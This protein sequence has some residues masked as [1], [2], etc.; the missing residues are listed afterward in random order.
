M[1]YTKELT[2]IINHY[3]HLNQ[4]IVAMEEFDELGQAVAKDLRGDG[5]RDNLVE[6]IADCEIMLTQLRIIYGLGESVEVIKKL[7]IERQLKR[8]ENEKHI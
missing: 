7:K 3:G 6:E 4:K 2:K 1:L 8:I 5:D